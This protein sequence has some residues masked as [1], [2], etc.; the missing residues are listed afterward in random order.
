M[1]KVASLAVLFVLM[2]GLTSCEADNTQEALYDAE[3]T[4]CNDFIDEDAACT[5]C[6][7]E[8]DMD[9][10]CTTCSGEIDMDSE[11]TTCSGDLPDGG[12]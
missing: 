10:A 9:A 7:G 5:T 11:C 8:I 1:K 6:S 2:I 3:C 4:T 12:K